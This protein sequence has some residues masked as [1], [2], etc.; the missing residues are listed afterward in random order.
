MTREA[1]FAYVRQIADLMHREH[2]T[3]QDDQDRMDAEDCAAEIH[4]AGERRCCG[5]AIK[6]DVLTRPREEIREIVVHELAHSH[7]N[8]VYAP[9]NDLCDSRQLSQVAYDLAF[10]TLRREVE[11]AT[12]SVTRV[13]MSYMPLPPE[14]KDDG[15]EKGRTQEGC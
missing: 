15:E 7:I 10:A 14:E 6:A 13:L 12:D 8:R 4:F 5:I 11:A 2:W 1:F 9:L 3:I